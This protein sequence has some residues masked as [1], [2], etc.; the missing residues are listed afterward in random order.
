MCGLVAA[1]SGKPRCDSLVNS[2]R[3]HGEPDRKSPWAWAGKT[4]IFRKG[5]SGG[6]RAWLSAKNLK[7]PQLRGIVGGMLAGS[8]LPASVGFG[9][10]RVLPHRRELLVDGQPA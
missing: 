3:Q 1:G 8:G 7:F 6:P 5:C 4:W 2:W 9:R 10:F